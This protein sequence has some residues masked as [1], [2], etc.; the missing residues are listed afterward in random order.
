MSPTI[1]ESRKPQYLTAECISCNTPVEFLMPKPNGEVIYIEC[2][3]CKQ[4]LS[5]DIQYP[6]KGAA[7]STSSTPNSSNSNT[8]KDAPSSKPK[9]TGTGTDASPLESELYDILGVPVDASPSLIKKNYRA[10]ALQNHPDKNP[11]P[12][13]H[14][15]FQKISEAYQIL[16]D[17]KLR[18]D[19]NMYGQNKDVSPEGGFVN[20]EA[21]FKQQF[22]GDRFVDIIGEISIGRDMRDALNEPEDESTA[23]LSPEE[24]AKREAS[25]SEIKDK[26]RDEARQARVDKLVKNLIHKLSIYTDG[27]CD[28]AAA[29]AYQEIIRLEAEELKAESYG[30]ELLHAIGFTYTLKAKQYLGK[31]EMLGL[32]SWFHGVREKGHILS[33]TVS[34][35]RAAMDLQQSFTQLQEAE[36]EPMD[37]AAKKALEEAAASKGIRALW[38][39][40]KLEVE[41]VLRDVCDKTLSDPTVPKTTLIKRASAL[42]I[43]GAVFEAVKADKPAEP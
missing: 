11:D 37:E 4:V 42:K 31:N 19:Y 7:S 16:S 40:S 38:K 27:P 13:A 3:A 12:E 24:K 28:Y 6:P 1:I 23:D 5:I 15:K 36:K 17:P 26:A 41:G 32:G 43:I 18:S 22:G 25:V 9:R 35:L 20:P 14:A 8:K 2:Y 29:K 39:G 10:L 34:T 33:E 30:V 21:F